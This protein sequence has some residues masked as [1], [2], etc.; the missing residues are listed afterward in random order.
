MLT[1]QCHFLNSKKIISYQYSTDL[2]SEKRDGYVTFTR[3]CL[4][5]GLCITVCI[6]FQNST[7]LAAIFGLIVGLY[8][9][10]SE[11]WLKNNPTPKQPG[12]EILEAAMGMN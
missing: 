9:S 7:W 8:I 12:Q 4:Y 6:I 1:E 2:S 3:Y 10:L 5:L 11:Y